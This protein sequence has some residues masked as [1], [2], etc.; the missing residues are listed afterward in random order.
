MVL[1]RVWPVRRGRP[2]T[3]TLPPIKTAADVVTAFGAVADAMAAGEL[4]PEEASAVAGV[5]EAKR[6][7]IET[8]ELE[9]RLHRSKGW[10]W[11]DEKHSAGP[12][13]T[14][15]RDGCTHR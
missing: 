14:E 8:A 10:G 6:R 3:L 15:A 7:A 1:A 5:L 9:E 4:T 13:P 12:A 11:A 2:V